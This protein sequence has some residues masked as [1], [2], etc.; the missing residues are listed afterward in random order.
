[1]L[2]L[3]LSLAV[4]P[5]V[6]WLFPQVVFLLTGKSVRRDGILL[7]AC[8][9]YLVSWYLPS[10]L[11]QGTDTSF[12]THFIGGGVFAGLLWLSVSK[13]LKW[14]QPWLNELTGLFALVC[15]LGVLN[16]LFEFATVELGLANLNPS[17]T[18]WD[19]LA[20]TLGVLSFWM[21]YRAW[22]LLTKQK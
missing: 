7:I 16:E 5:V 14:K 18:W 22:R 15:T 1:M 19:L 21:T 12:T 2:I 13:Q 11:I 17:D 8:I 20:N 4:P 3:L 6:Y 10:P 9:I